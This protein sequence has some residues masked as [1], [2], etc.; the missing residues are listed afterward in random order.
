MVSIHIQ[1]PS[2]TYFLSEPNAFVN[3]HA[4]ALLLMAFT[5]RNPIK[6]QYQRG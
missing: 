4:R 2:V 3:H 6:H 1:L 5:R